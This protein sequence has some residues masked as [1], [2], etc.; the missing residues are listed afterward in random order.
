MGYEGPQYRKGR[1]HHRE[2]L[3]EH[4]LP[5]GDRDG[6]GVVG[7]QGE[8]RQAQKDEEEARPGEHVPVSPSYLVGAFVVA[9]VLTYHIVV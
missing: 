4:R 1:R 9:F 7:Q 3:G 8:R 2:G 6:G 5:R